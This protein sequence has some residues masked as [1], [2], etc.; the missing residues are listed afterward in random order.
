MKDTISAWMAKTRTEEYCFSA[1]SWEPEFQ[2]KEPHHR[3]VLN[4]NS[5]W[6]EKMKKW[7]NEMRKWNEKMKWEDEMRK[8]IVVAAMQTE[9]D[10][11]G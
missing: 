6:T 10:G 9:K 1:W 8:L 5:H 2:V 11:K 4:E 7:E 3:R